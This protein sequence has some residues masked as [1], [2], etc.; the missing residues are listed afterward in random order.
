MGLV[1]FYSNIIS[2]S[3]TPALETFATKV[4]TV[5]QVHIAFKLSQC[6][7]NI[8]L[9]GKDSLCLTLSSQWSMIVL[10]PVRK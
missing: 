2:T 9:L 10:L 1:L 4:D 5:F 7:G 6:F 8:L 3:E